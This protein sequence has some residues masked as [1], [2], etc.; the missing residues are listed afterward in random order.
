MIKNK[1]ILLCL[2]L[3]LISIIMLFIISI[4]TNSI[5]TKVNDLHQ[6][7]GIEK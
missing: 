5:S 3:L 2:T 6:Q 7:I 1:K 4:K